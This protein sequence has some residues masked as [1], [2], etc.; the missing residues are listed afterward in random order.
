MIVSDEEANINDQQEI[1]DNSFTMV[2]MTIESLFNEFDL[3]EG[4]L[5]NNERKELIWF[6]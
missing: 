2:R 1:I 4:F 5:V 6:V 3:Y